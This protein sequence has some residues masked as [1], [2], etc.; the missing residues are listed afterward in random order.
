[1]QVSKHSGTTAK[2]AEK[3]HREGGAQCHE[4][5]IVSL[6]SWVYEAKSNCAE[7]EAS[8]RIRVRG[9]EPRPENGRDDCGRESAAEELNELRYAAR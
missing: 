1:V 4:D 8:E 6:S 3:S 5:S 7:E 2:P 9:P